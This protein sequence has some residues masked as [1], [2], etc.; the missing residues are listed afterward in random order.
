[1]MKGILYLTGAIL[2]EVF[3]STMLK[4]SQG[5]S[6]FFAEYRGTDRIWMRLYFPELGT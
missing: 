3:G 6:R 2:T 5:F 1:M 4:L